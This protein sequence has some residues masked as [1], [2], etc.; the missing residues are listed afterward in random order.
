MTNKFASDTFTELAKAGVLFLVMGM[1][2]WMLWQKVE[3]YDKDTKHDL[4]ELK[5]E[6]QECRSEYQ[7]LLLEQ[8]E[9]TTEVIERNTIVIE[10]LK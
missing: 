3:E 6:T 9:K 4:R 8:V 10:Q 1:G 5:I 7:R 2:L